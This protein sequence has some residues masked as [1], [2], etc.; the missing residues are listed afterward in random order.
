MGWGRRW[1]EVN[2][3][4]VSGHRAA[5]AP[6]TSQLVT[7]CVGLWLV[8]HEHPVVLVLI[9]GLQV[10]WFWADPRCGLGSAVF[11]TSFFRDQQGRPLW[12]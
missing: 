7:R 3:C 6:T 10:G 5:R 8:R 4:R 9:L 11:A 1:R 12:W 2:G